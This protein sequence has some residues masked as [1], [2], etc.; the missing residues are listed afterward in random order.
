MKEICLCVNT[1]WNSVL[2]T[3]CTENEGS[4]FD[5]QKGQK[6]SLIFKASRPPLNPTQP[7]T[8][9]VLR[10]EE[11]SPGLGRPAREAETQQLPFAV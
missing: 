6:V 10:G 3:D 7:P 8:Q 1:I 4:E 2:A 11:G 5:Y 9:P